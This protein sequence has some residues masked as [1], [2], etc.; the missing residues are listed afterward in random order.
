MLT[1][2]L[3]GM[4]KE[5]FLQTSGDPQNGKGTSVLFE[6]GNPIDL[7]EFRLPKDSQQA[8]SVIDEFHKSTVAY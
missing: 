5:F 8:A 6:N 3:K 7:I 4:G 2:K 1:S